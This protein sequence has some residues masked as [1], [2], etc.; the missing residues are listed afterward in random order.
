MGTLGANIDFERTPVSNKS[1]V[2]LPF[3][4]K[5]ALHHNISHRL[6]TKTYGLYTKTVK[7]FLK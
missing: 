5:V 7:G 2:K 6:I 1:L 4:Y 3:T